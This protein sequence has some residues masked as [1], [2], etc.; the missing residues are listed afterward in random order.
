[1]GR[2]YNIPSKYYSVSKHLDLGKRSTFKI[3]TVEFNW[4]DNQFRF[5]EIWKEPQIAIQGG[6]P[7]T[8]AYFLESLDFVTSDSDY[9]LD[10]VWRSVATEELTENLNPDLTSI[11]K[12]SLLTLLLEY[13]DVIAANPKIPL[14]LREF[15]TLFINSGN[16]TYKTEEPPNGAFSRRG[17]YAPSIGNYFQ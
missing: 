15:Y 7:L 2:S 1:M 10:T 13:S 4:L 12:N 6:E 17:N 16:A 5:G 8:R 9:K 3:A 14:R 11:L